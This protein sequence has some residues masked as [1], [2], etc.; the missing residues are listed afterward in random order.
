MLMFKGL[1]SAEP[2]QGHCRPFFPVPFQGVLC[3]R[4]A[5][6][7]VSLAGGDLLAQFQRI[8]FKK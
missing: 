2:D 5:G 3:P 6:V 8:K 7:A 1:M 4:T